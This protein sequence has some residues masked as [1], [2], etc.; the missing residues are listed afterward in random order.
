MIPFLLVAYKFC[1][2]VKRNFVEKSTFNDFREYFRQDLR[3]NFR[4]IWKQKVFFST[5]SKCR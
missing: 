3:E 4:H 5:L 1:L 2:V